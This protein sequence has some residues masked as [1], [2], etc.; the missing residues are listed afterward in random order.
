[1]SETDES[2]TERGYLFANDYTELSLVDHSS[3]LA[4]VVVL[5]ER[6]LNDLLRPDHGTSSQYSQYAVNIVNMQSICS[7]Y[8]QYAV[9]MQSICS[10][11]TV[12]HSQSTVTIHSICSQRLVN[13]QLI[14]RN[15]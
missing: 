4:I 12:I 7:Q 1:M 15:W 5:T 10:Q 14:T 9:N 11:Y 2:V 13:T 3:R 8:S 6:S